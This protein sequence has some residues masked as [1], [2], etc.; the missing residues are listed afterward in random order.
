VDAISF[1]VK[2]I[3]AP[4]AFITIYG[5]NMGQ[6]ERFGFDVPGTFP[7]ELGGLQVQFNGKPAPLLYVS[8]GQ[9][10]LQ[11][12]YDLDNSE[13]RLVIRRGDVVS[14]PAALGVGSASPAVA[15]VSG[16]GSGQGQVYRILP[17]QAAAFATPDNPAKVG[18]TILVVATGLGA[19]NPFFDEGKAVPTDN[20]LNVAS[21]VQILV[22]DVA[23]TNVQGYL[24]PGQI[25]IYFVT[26]TVPE[27]SPTGDAVNV[28]V[29]ANGVDS[30]T[31]T[32][33]IQ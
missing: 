6:V 8:P 25:G 10:N 28:V 27:G 21:T 1:R 15:T 23:A 9:V 22:G 26:A 11:V 20:L 13:Y 32:M 3:T 4:G 18:D 33:A 17:E 2:T 30:Q 12:P 14:A 7:T 31:V 16:T 5:E 29:R 24:A 19:T